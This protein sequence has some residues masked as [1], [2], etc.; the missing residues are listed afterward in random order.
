MSMK[1]ATALLLSIIFAFSLASCQLFSSDDKK[2]YSSNYTAFIT[3]KN[4]SNGSNQ[5]DESMLNTY[6][7]ILTGDSV[8]EAVR[9][10]LDIKYTKGEIKNSIQA[11]VAD[12]SKIIQI[13]ATAETPENAYKI[14]KAHTSVA[15]QYITMYSEGASMKIIDYP[16]L[17]K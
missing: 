15:P 7:S 12:N 9:K 3:E 13:T 5:P 6:I 17:S 8:C 16:K 14:A 11:N 1:K 4:S 2:E 10:S